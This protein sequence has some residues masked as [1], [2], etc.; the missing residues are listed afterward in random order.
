MST[1]TDTYSEDSYSLLSDAGQSIISITDTDKTVYSS[2]TPE[3]KLKGVIENL[4]EDVKKA[5]REVD[6]AREQLA[7]NLEAVL[8]EGRL[9]MTV[10]DVKEQNKKAEVSAR[11]AG[12]LNWPFSETQR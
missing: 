12:R 5:Q 1:P 8:T 6:E 7:K 11:E 4:E 3:D 10:E 2:E 9:K